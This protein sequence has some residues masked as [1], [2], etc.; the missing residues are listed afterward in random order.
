MMHCSIHHYHC[1]SEK[2]EQKDILY[3]IVLW[4]YSV[5]AL[6]VYS[7]M[8]CSLEIKSISLESGANTGTPLRTIECD[9]DCSGSAMVCLIQA[10]RIPARHQKLVC[11]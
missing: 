6:K 10:T 2:P 1:L 11:I 8:C 4:L 7:N 9:K 3:C 5:P